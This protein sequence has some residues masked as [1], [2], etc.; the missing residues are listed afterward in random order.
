MPAR[1]K[2]VIKVEKDLLVRKMIRFV[3]HGTIFHRHVRGAQETAS[4]KQ[5]LRQGTCP[6]H[7]QFRDSGALPPAGEGRT[8]PARATP[9]E[10]RAGDHFF[11]RRPAALRDLARDRPAFPSSCHPNEGF[12]EPCVPPGGASTRDYGP[13]EKASRGDSCGTGQ[14]GDAGTTKGKRLE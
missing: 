1:R 13:R 10:R 9:E 11:G 6:K 2:L 5:I 7:R 8:D 14:A 12:R 4:G 3:R